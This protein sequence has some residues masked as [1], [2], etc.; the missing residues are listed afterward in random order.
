MLVSRYRGTLWLLVVLAAASVPAGGCARHKYLEVRRVPGNPLAGPLSLLSYKGPQPTDRTLH[1]LRKYDLEEAYKKD[2]DGALAQLQQE[3]A[4]EPTA[5]K[6]Q[7]FSELAYIAAFKADARG[8][9]A[10]ALNLYGVTVFYAYDYLFDPLYDALRNPYDPQFRRV[11]DLYNTGLEAAM[12]LINRDG[13]LLPG[14][15]L[16]FD[17]GMEQIRVE[18]VAR[19]SWS[20]DEFEKLEFVSDYQITGL[21]NRHHG[22]GLGVPMIAVRRTRNPDDPVERYYPATLTFPVTAFLRILPTEPSPRGSAGRRCVLEFCDPLDSSTT[23][24]ANRLVPLETDLSTPLGYGLEQGKTSRAL[25]ISTLGLLDPGKIESKQ[26]LYMVEAFDPN[27]IPVLM[28]HGLW[29]S[30]MTWMEMFNDLLAYPE[31]RSN[32][33][34]WFYLYPTG[35]P[36]WKSA[37]QLRADLAEAR[38]VLD[39]HRINPVFDRMVMVGHSMGGLVSMMQ[40]L[41]SG[42]DFWNLVSDQ[43]FERLQATPE[44]RDRIAQMVF[45]EPDPSVQEVITIGTPHRGSTFA[46]EYTRYLARKLIRLPSRML[47]VTQRLT[48]EN[49]GFFRNTDLLTIST[50]VDSLAPNSPIFPAMLAAKRAPWVGYHNIV[51]VVPKDSLWSRFAERGDGVVG[52][53]SAHRDDFQSELVVE[54]DHM[55]VHAHPR[56]ILEVRR[57]LLDHLS[58]ARGPLVLPPLTDLHPTAPAA[59]QAGQ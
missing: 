7:A 50:S 36:F 31:I 51:G 35:E 1:T 18:I 33:Q 5:D 32:Y 34:F 57:I 27:K 29:S 12:R 4:A 43:P 15:N 21:K 17:T 38:R 48:L 6:L 20:A 59:A 28:V 19:G 54:A 58:Q 40:T 39:P 10:R 41:E 55:T 25:E 3:I 26:G 2:P 37:E 22:Y 47:W 44:V 42:N 16:T 14:S 30:P 24:V 9:R 45:F 56:T 8:Q 52:F 11:C 53:D 46:N 13:K 49:P 23:V